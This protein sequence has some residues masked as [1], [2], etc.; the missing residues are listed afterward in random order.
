MVRKLRIQ[1]IVIE[2]T[3][4]HE[5]V[6]IHVT[7]QEVQYDEDGVQVS[8]IPSNHYAHFR[9]EDKA[10]EMYDFYDPV[11]KADGYHSGVGVANGVIKSC[12]LVLQEK[13]GG[14]LEQDF[15][16]L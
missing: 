8:V 4:E 11:I 16:C 5:P 6:W 7:G 13:Y 9:L 15:L 12:L 14:T 1:R 2:S 3:V 10:T